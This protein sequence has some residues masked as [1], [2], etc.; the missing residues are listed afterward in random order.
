MS[1]ITSR[2]LTIGLSEHRP[3]MI[4]LI[5]SA[6]QQHQAILL[7]EPADEGFERMLTGMLGVDDYLRGLD[8][9]YP[10]FSREM[11]YLLRKLRA[12]GKEILQVEPYLEILLGIHAYFAD[13][14]GPDELDRDSIQYPV[15]LVERNATRALISFYNISM[16]ASFEYTLEA[17]KH[18][19]RTDAARFRLRDSLRAQA[20]ASLAHELPSVY[21]EAGVIH[22]PLWRRLRREMDA[23]IRLRLLF[24]ADE[25]QGFANS[26]KHRYGPGDKLTLLYIFH[27]IYSE[28]NRENLLAARALI[29]SKLIAK[30]ELTEELKSW[31]H[32][33]DEVKC[34]HTTN[35]LSLNDCRNLYPRVRNGNTRQ[36]HQVVE[37]YLSG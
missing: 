1:N 33:Q 6:M 16:R 12:A 28:M 8:V 4:P 34:I 13:G 19:A 14:H 3:E 23:S 37:A 20:L 36:A 29:Y 26:R 27:P 32:L 22:Y 31:P 21:V 18:F 35:R 30:N 10:A 17:V 5:A 11:C 7:E 25:A 9:E 2:R 15:Y 24:L